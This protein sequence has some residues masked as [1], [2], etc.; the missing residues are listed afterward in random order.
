MSCDSCFNEQRSLNDLFQQAIIDAQNLSNK[1]NKKVA[2]IAEA[3][4]F[5]I[6]IITDA[7]PGGTCKITCPV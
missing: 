4:Q 2:V 1:E 7:I 3:G 5:K 6:H